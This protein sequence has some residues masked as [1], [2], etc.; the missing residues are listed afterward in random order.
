MIDKN[1]IEDL[2]RTALSNGLDPFPV[3][4]TEVESKTMFN[5]ISYGLPIR[6]RHWSYGRSYEHSKKYGEMGLSKVYEMIVNSNPSYAFMLDTNTE[7]QDMFIVPH[8][9]AHSDFFKNNCM[10]K[11]SDR[12]MVWHAAE[13]ATRI[14]KYIERYGIERVEHTMDIGFALDSHI[15]WHKGFNRKRYPEKC[16]ISRFRKEGE[17]DD[18]VFRKKKRDYIIKTIVNKE[19]PPHPEKDLLWFLT[20]YAPLE[21]WERDVLDIIR[22][23][24][25]YFHPQRMTKIMNEGWAS[26]WHAEIMYKFDLPPEKFLDFA[27]NHEKVVQPGGNP[28]RINPYF[29]GFKI[30]KDIEK[31]WDKK[32]GKGRGKD[33]IFEVRAEDDDISFLRN[34]LTSELVEELELFTYGYVK[35]YPDDYKGERYIEIKERLRDEIVEHLVKPL[36]NGGS[37]KIVITGVGSEGSLQMYHDSEEV[38]V[39]NQRYAAKTLEYVWDL[40]AAPIELYV[41]DDDDKD[42]SL[43][44]DEAGFYKKHL[45]EELNFDDET[46]FIISS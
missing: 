15:D 21:E 12:S 33:K 1:K 29:L 27:R 45:E 39:L 35:N 28:F 3:I 22:E 23:E 30:F 43:C 25:Y 5:I 42:I 38:G 32:Y 4:F 13:H 24:A 8:C 7:I 31:R 34:Y 41:R 16:T 17:F 2:T 20:T 18:L 6:S 40:W 14:E 46:N 26:Y 10:F 9:L 19:I 44:F 11:N 36:Y 37:P